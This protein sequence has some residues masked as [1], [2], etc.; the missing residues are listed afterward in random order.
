MKPTL[1]VDAITIEEF[2]R[3]KGECLDNEVL[4][5]ETLKKIE[6]LF[7]IGDP[8]TG[9][10]ACDDYH[11]HAY[12]CVYFYSPVTGVVNRLLDEIG[13]YKRKVEGIRAAVDKISGSLST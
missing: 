9:R 5:E 11:G 13:H 4:S 2:E 1:P 6:E 3:L 7:G 10:I 12:R 8:K